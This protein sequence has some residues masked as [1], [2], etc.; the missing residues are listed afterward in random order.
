MKSPI[1]PVEGFIQHTQ[2]EKGRGVFADRNFTEGE[3]I[4][5]A[6]VIILF[7]PFQKLPEKLKTVVYNWGAITNGRTCS[8]LALGYGSLYNHNNPAN[9]RYKPDTENETLSYIAVRDIRKGEELTVNYNN[10]KGG[11]KSENDDWFKR[12][13]IEPINYE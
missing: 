12:N 8:A 9:M 2:T 3:L 7:Q 5:N 6:P 1:Y 11:P 4:E 10:T 13:N